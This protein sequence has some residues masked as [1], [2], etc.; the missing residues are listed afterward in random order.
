MRDRMRNDWSC[1][2]EAGCKFE[3]LLGRTLLKRKI[4]L[5]GFSALG[6]TNQSEANEKQ[7]ASKRQLQINANH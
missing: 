1:S 5:R 2:K 4:R 6:Q 7:V 3:D